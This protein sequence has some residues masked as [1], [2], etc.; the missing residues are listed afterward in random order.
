MPKCEDNAQLTTNHP[1]KSVVLLWV[2][3]VDLASWILQID[4]ERI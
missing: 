3:F 4:P 1:N 2:A